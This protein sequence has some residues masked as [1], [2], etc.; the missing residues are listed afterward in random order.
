MLFYL[1]HLTKPH[2]LYHQI[3]L[4]YFLLRFTALNSTI[5]TTFYTLLVNTLLTIH[6]TVPL[7]HTLVH[8]LIHWSKSFLMDYIIF[9]MSYVFLSNIHA[10]IIINIRDTERNWPIEKFG[11]ILFIRKPDHRYNL[12]VL[13]LNTTYHTDHHS[14]LFYL[15]HLTKPHNLYHQIL[16]FAVQ[17]FTFAYSVPHCTKPYYAM[18]DHTQPD[19]H[20]TMPT[21]KD[22]SLLI[23]HPMW[24]KVKSDIQLIVSPFSFEY[25]K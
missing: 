4:F 9:T 18:I 21:T 13:S 8:Q 12:T 24:Q 6:I 7:I 10:W 19:L 14:M 2:N 5:L 3:L 23:R 17:C 1:L 11:K 16:N 25:S 20:E 22:I 15:L